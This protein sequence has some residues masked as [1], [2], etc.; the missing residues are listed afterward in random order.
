[1]TMSIRDL[2]EGIEDALFVHLPQCGHFGARQLDRALQYAI[3]PGGKRLRPTFSLLGARVFGGD[4][5]LALPA[6][7]AVEFIH[8][9][10]LIFDDLPCMDDAERRRGLPVLHRVYGEDVALLAGIALLNQAY[11]LFGRQPLLLE[12]AVLC[13]G[14][15]GMIGGQALDVAMQGA[16]KKLSEEHQQN[17][18]DRNRKTS[19]MMRLAL[20]SGALAC[21]FSHDEV[22]PL[23]RA[24]EFLGEAFQIC[25][26]LVDGHRCSG[27]TGKPTGQ[28]GR[29]RRLSYGM[30]EEQAC[31]AQVTDLIEQA[32]QSLENAYE[33]A[34]I[35]EL[36]M[37]V[38]ALFAKLKPAMETSH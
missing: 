38:D 25:D 13:I 7:C 23:G 14:V 18:R 29:H 3:F 4:L 12:E 27:E 6:A 20:T 35:A 10:S 15:K 30:L 28:D 8:T 11:A 32:R 9:S 21:G 22:A 34:Q 19:A 33:R 1:M 24:G 17:L 16:E 26:D 36:M 37:S 5:K 31:L 2:Q